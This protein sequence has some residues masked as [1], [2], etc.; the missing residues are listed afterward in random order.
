MEKE[1]SI[2][3]VAK[4]SGFSTAT[5]SRVLNRRGYISKEAEETILQAARELNYTPKKY[6][7]RKKETVHNNTVGIIAAD[8]KNIF[9]MEIV[10]HAEAEL[11]NR[12]INVIISDSAESPQKEVRILNY[13]KQ[14][15]INGIIITPV[16]E[17][18]S[19]NME[20]LAQIKQDGIPVV[21]MDRDIAGHSFD[22]IFQDNINGAVKA[23]NAFI[24]QGH[25]NIATIAGPLTSRPGAERLNGYMQA[26]S[27]HGIPMHHEYILYGDFQTDTGYRLAT[28][29]I[30]KFPEV[31][32]VFC[33]NNLM[34]VGALRAIRDKNLKVP[35][36]I[37][38]ISFGTLNQFSLYN[39]APITEITQPTEAMGRESARMMLKIL[40]NPSLQ[41]S[42]PARRIT[43]DTDLVVKGSEQYPRNR[44]PSNIL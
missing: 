29:I 25:K 43:F 5:V 22:G 6:A 35:D 26:L 15:R 11:S 21:L 39:D 41:H 1:V 9:F 13:Y 34:A 24:E 31:T 30:E 19:Y 16:S 44:L 10:H 18:S 33:A 3:D 38:L 14:Q 17:T 27:V 20:Y 28:E 23:V 7:S 2:Q 42:N 37:A 4:R 8:L 40:S 32:A 36:D 12:G